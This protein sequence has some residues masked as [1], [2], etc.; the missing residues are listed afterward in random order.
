MI[1]VFETL[2]LLSFRG[3]FLKSEFP[4]APDLLIVVYVKCRHQSIPPPDSLRPS[5]KQGIYFLDAK[6]YS[7]G[8]FVHLL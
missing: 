1:L 5:L 6:L 2:A 8:F 7:K 3:L 4:F